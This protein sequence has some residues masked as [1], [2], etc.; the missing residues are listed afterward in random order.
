MHACTPTL[1]IRR[2]GYLSSIYYSTLFFLPFSAPKD[3]PGTYLGDLSRYV[4]H[5]NLSSSVIEV[6]QANAFFPMEH[7]ST[8]NTLTPT[9]AARSLVTPAPPPKQPWLSPLSLSLGLSLARSTLHTN[10]TRVAHPPIRWD[11]VRFRYGKVGSLPRPSL[12][13]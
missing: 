4:G 1:V 11:A 13:R 2:L 5:L 12:R 8:P 6:S 10:S 7:S 3:R 9:F